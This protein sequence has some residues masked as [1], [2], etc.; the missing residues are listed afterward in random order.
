MSQQETKAAKSRKRFSEVEIRSSQNSWG[1]ANLGGVSNV[2]VA[3]GAAHIALE[4]CN[5]HT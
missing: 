5:M 4:P 2:L 3:V 1:H